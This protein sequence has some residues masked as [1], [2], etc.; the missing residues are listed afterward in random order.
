[1]TKL[2]EITDESERKSKLDFV[3][4][5]WANWR[6]G[7]QLTLGRITMYLFTLNTGALLAVLTYVAAKPN[8]KDI[9]L[10]IWLFSAGILC[11]VLHAAL[12]Y[13]M[14]E[15]YFSAYRKDVKKLYD[16]HMDW[17][18]FVE[19]NE[20]RDKYDWLLHILGWSGAISFFVALINGIL[21]LKCT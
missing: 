3:D 19:R 12:D 1:M 15:G 10:S 16:N 5:C 4:E 21:Q 7:R 13:Y 11:S 6:E 9:Q 14:T 18:A 2:N 20:N 17:N 8:N